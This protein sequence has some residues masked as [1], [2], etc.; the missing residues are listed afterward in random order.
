M[1]DGN[2]LVLGVG[3]D[4]GIGKEGPETV[5]AEGEVTRGLTTGNVRLRRG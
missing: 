1:T 4:G 5:L 3:D 2:L